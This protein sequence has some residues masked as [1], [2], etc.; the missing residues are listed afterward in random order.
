MAQ[1]MTNLIHKDTGDG[2]ILIL[3]WNYSSITQGTWSIVISSAYWY[4]AYF[5]NSSNALNDQIDYK[6]YVPRGTYTVSFLGLIA[7][8]GYIGLLLDSVLVAAL[9]TYGSST[10][11]CGLGRA[12]PDP[13][14]VSTTGVHTLSFKII[15]SGVLGAT[16]YFLPTHLL[17]QRAN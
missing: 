3:P 6:I 1:G 9:D 12:W 14:F 16:Y 10:V 4:N 17:V 5:F 13:I 8:Y 11:I 2:T 7:N 15:G